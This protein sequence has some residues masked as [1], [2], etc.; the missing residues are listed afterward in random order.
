MDKILKKVEIK[1]FITTALKSNLKLI[2]LQ[3]LVA[4]RCIFYHLYILDYARKIDT[5]IEKTVSIFRTQY[6]SVQN[7]QTLQ[8]YIFLILQHFATKLC[9]FSNYRMLFNAVVVNFHI[10]TFFQNSV[11]N[12]IGPFIPIRWF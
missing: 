3:S 11:H 7:S 5:N 1:K 6:K 10:S 2:K 9:N 12:A 4:K 8:G